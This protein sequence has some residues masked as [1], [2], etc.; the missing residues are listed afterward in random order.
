M[1]KVGF[2]GVGQMGKHM[3]ARL[4]E[5][6]YDL[7]LHDLLREGAQHL[8]Q[9]GA[10]WINSPKGLAEKCE[11]VITCLPGPPEVEAV[12]YGEQGLM[13]GWKKGDIYV[14]MSTNSPITMRRVAEDAKALGVGVL[15]APVSGGTKGA[16]EG[17]LSIMVGGDALH[18]ETVREM[19]GTMG[20][21]IFHVGDVGCGD[22]AKLV[23]NMN[24][25]TC[26]ALNAESFVL[27]VKAGIDPYR[28]WE[29]I[30]VSTG[31]NQA[32]QQYP[33][34]VFKGN[35]QPGFRLKL[36]LKDLDLALDL[37]KEYGLSLPVIYAAEQKFAEANAAGLG[38][39][40]SQAVITRLEKAAGVEVRSAGVSNDERSKSEPK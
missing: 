10:Q 22:I 31:N 36:A 2:I 30:S 37:A 14:D 33:K 15:D 20:S 18:L 25:I 12:V 27:G 5:A 16:E 11:V 1:I 34:T 7:T 6:G 35:F 21:K 17:T 3:A 29:V 26:S 19:L 23:N 9:K 38:E 32:L 4:L 8:L 40:S 13:A 24:A 28:L 39:K